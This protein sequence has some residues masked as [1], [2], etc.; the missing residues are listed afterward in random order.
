MSILGTVQI[1]TLFQVGKGAHLE[2]HFEYNGIE[3]RCALSKTDFRH[4]PAGRLRRDI[5][6]CTIATFA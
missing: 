6:A 4:F 2:F 1:I 3:V 5:F